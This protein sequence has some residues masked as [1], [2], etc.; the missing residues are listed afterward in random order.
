MNGGVAVRALLTGNTALT[1]LVPESR[2]TA[3]IL[4]Q[5]S[6]LPAIALMSISGV[7]RNILKPGSRR[8]VTERVQVSV[9]AAT[10]PAAKA[11]MRVVRATA[12]DQM[13]TVKGIEN[14]VVHTDAAGPD[15]TD[16]K[17]GIFIQT[18]DLRVSFLETV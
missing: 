6:N 2:I 17:T 5:G 15:F 12:A 9:L 8:Q 1:A 3:G 13:P 4:P 10:Y 7:D 11:M 14:V 18:Q 16:P